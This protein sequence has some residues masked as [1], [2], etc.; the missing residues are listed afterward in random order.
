MLLLPGCSR[1]VIGGFVDSPDS[2]YRMYGRVYGVFGRAFL[3]DTD[4]TVRIS[5]VLNDARET[6]L[7]RKEIR[8]KGSDVGWHY[9]GRGWKPVHSR[10]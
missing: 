8:V 9:Q 4:K 10:F 5:I 1:T 3:D 2:K 7:F 6:I